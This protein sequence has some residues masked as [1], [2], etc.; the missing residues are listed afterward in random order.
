MKRCLHYKNT[1][2]RLLIKK[3]HNAK[4]DY[5]SR[6]IVIKGIEKAKIQLDIRI[7]T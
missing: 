4:I 1:N 2:E 3:R 5:T 7:K 6:N